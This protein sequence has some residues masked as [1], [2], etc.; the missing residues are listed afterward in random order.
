VCDARAA[1]RATASFQE[2]GG[3]LRELRGVGFQTHTF[4]AALVRLRYIDWLRGVAVLFMVM[5]HSIDAWTVQTGRESWA[6][7]LILFAAG[8]AAPLFLLL[9]G[10]SVSLAAGARTKRGIARAEASWGLQKRGW[11]IFLLAHVFRFQSFLLNPNGTWNSILKPDILNILGLGLVAAAYCWRY[12]VSP[13]RAAGWLVGPALL[14]LALTP[15]SREWWWPT[16]LHVRF[17]A[18]IRPVGNFGVFSIF[19]AVA[20][21]F[22]GAFVG[23][24]VW[25]YREQERWLH[26]RLAW[27][28]VALIAIGASLSAIDALEIPSPIDSVPF[29][30]WRTGVMILAFAGSWALL[31]RRSADSWS[32]LV[33]FGQTSLFVYWIHVEICYGIFTH[34]IRHSLPLSVSFTAYLTFTVLLFWAAMLWQRRR[35]GPLIP[36]HLRA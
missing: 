6:F 3:A 36:V 31:A 17:E 12:A 5:W 35:Q 23:W 1:L 2:G 34:P 9:A 22:V 18:Y 7:T 24:L 33:V 29:F 19:P 25:E 13:K 14:V 30:A 26:G 21:V 10:V 4:I 15:L 11:Q 8:W 28:A 16:L 27:A 20:Y 32:P